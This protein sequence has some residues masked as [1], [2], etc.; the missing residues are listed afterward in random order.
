MNFPV[1]IEA[2]ATGGTWA[3][4]LLLTIFSILDV[5]VLIERAIF[6]YQNKPDKANELILKLRELILNNNMTEALTLTKSDK[7]AH[8]RLIASALEY[9]Q[10]HPDERED[11]LGLELTLDNAIANE[12]LKINKFIGILG[13]IGAIGP[14]VGLFG[15][16]LGI[17]RSFAGIASHG[18]TGQGIIEVA[19]GGIWEALT[20]TAFGILV[21]VPALI[22]YNY[23]ARQ[24][25]TQLDILNNTANQIITIEIEK[26]GSKKS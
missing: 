25:N 14:L 22:L 2:L 1:P 4:V 12:K 13:T 5:A 6:F 16:V 19:A 17:M 15:T 18:S 24:A 23:F 26:K 11:S 21:S 3:T 7:K 20:T 8:N 10:N 9:M